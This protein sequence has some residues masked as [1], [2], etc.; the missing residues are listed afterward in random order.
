MTR[1]EQHKKRKRGN[2]GEYRELFFGTV[3]VNPLN[4]FVLKWQ[5]IEAEE[6]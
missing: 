5:L 3:Y 6:D 2:K 4:R 1:L